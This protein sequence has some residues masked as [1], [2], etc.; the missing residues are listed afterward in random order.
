MNKL[1]RILR[2]DWPIHLV[3]L[4][5]NWLPDNVAVLRFRGWLAHF[6]LGRCGKDFRVGRSVVFYN[7]ANITIGKNVYIAYGNWFSASET[8]N[9]GD[10]VV[11]GPKNIF[12]SGNHTKQN[13]S[14]RYG[15]PESSPIEVGKGTWIGANCTI[16]AGVVIG[17]GAVIGANTVVTKNVPDNVLFAGNPGKVIKDI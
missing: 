17:S 7:P 15:K 8:I 12:A 11:L 1:Y 14:F 10:E 13:G 2:Y 9:L 6:F 5:T 4:F 3:L 16:T